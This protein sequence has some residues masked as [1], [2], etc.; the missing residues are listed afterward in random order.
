MGSYVL[1]DLFG[2]VIGQIFKPGTGTWTTWS[3]RSSSRRNDQL[4]RGSTAASRREITIAAQA[5]HPDLIAA[6]GADEANGIRFL[7]VP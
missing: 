2:K 7:V 5:E 1:L 6:Y 3:H 4:A